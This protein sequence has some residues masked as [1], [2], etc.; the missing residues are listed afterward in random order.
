[1][2]HPMGLVAGPNTCLLHS[3]SLGWEIATQLRFKRPQQP[4]I[5]YPYPNAQ[6]TEQTSKSSL[7]VVGAGKNEAL[8]VD[9]AFLAACSTDET[10]ERRVGGGGLGSRAFRASPLK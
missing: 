7:M 2:A 3:V 1:M 10:W 8:H 4:Y 9:T 6:A 5:P